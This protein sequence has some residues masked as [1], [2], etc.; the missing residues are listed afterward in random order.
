MNNLV[1]GK[2]YSVKPHVYVLRQFY[3]Q[4]EVD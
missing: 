1:I 4:P 2:G 3:L